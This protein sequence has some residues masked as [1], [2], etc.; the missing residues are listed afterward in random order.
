MLT[1]VHLALVFF[2]ML[3]VNPVVAR[4]HATTYVKKYAMQMEAI[5]HDI[6]A[7]MMMKQRYKATMILL[8]LVT[9][10]L[11]KMTNLNLLITL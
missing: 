9:I 5:Q 2:L 10:H 7:Q 8:G 4:A 6:L 1:A 11:K 3:D